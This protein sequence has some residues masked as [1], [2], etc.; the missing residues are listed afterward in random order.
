MTNN[1]T[2][3]VVMRTDHLLLIPVS[4][5][6]TRGCE[7]G[8][9]CKDSLCSSSFRKLGWFLDTP[10]NAPLIETSNLNHHLPVMSD[11]LYPNIKWVGWVYHFSSCGEE[12]N[13]KLNY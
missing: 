13:P 6:P 1:Q 3:V 7:T 5:H 4:F 8:A 11:Y 10:S 2:M 12:E 9:G